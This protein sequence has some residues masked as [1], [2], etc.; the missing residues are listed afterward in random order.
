MTNSGV[1]PLHCSCYSSVQ[2]SLGVAGLGKPQLHLQQS[3]GANLLSLKGNCWLLLQGYKQQLPISK[4]WSLQC[5]LSPS[6]P[7][8]RHPY[9]L[10]T[11][12]H[13]ALE[14]SLF[15]KKK[16]SL[17]NSSVT[18][19]ISVTE[20]FLLFVQ[21]KEIANIKEYE[22]KGTRVWTINRQDCC[23]SDFGGLYNGFKY[24]LR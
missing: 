24:W 23:G 10:L 16:K 18:C 15:K 17:L 13:F 5:A 12:Y 4:S 7:A 19:S 3:P 20:L 6:S 11:I 22:K 9:F 1:L 14:G 2:R 8:P 21:I